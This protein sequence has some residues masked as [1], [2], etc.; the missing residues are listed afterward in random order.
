MVCRD[1]LPSLDSRAL[2]SG[3]AC[4]VVVGAKKG[5]GTLDR[6]FSVDESLDFWTLESESGRGLMCVSVDTAKGSNMTPVRRGR[7]AHR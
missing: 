1:A 7:A 6:K 2:S 3:P 5:A 4:F